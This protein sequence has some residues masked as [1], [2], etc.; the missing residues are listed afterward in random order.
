MSKSD[1]SVIDS[2]MAQFQNSVIPLAGKAGK[3]DEYNR[4]VGINMPKK[5]DTIAVE[6]ILPKCEPYV[7]E[8]M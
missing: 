8:V 4:P 3:E 6:G 7:Y 5:T 1:T 2:S